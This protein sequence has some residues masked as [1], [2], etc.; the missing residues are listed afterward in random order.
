MRLVSYNIMNGGEGRA[1]PLAEVIQAQ[2]PDVVVLVEAD[3]P[4]VTARIAERLEMDSIEA[5]GPRHTLAVLSRPRI[6]HS[7]NHA[8]LPRTRTVPRGGLLEV[9]LDGGLFLFAVHL[10]PG[11]DDESERARLEELDT[12]LSAIEES[13][14]SSSACVLAGD[15]NAVS[16]Q[17]AIDP[18]RLRPL[19][20]AQWDR[21]GG[22]LPREAV[23]RILRAGFRD[24]LETTD[25][26]FAAT[27]GT[28]DTQ[29]PGLRVDYVFVRNVF[30]AGAWIETDRLATY[31]SDHYPVGAELRRQS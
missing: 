14:G 12:V 29:H 6:V 31:A 5:S 24:S 19:T 13:A 23:A 10:G 18:G 28:L 7:V 20:R 8:A 1:D 21:N 3:C 15:F 17:A 9:G 26:K 22:R 4:A 27:A 2:R 11:A 25:P 16:P 30:V